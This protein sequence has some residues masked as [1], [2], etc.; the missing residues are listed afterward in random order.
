[1]RSLPVFSALLFSFAVS[2]EARAVTLYFADLPLTVQQSGDQVELNSFYS[3]GGVSAFATF[4]NSGGWGWLMRYDMT[5]PSGQTDFDGNQTAAYDGYLWM[6]VQNSYSAAATSHAITL[7]R[8]QVTP[9]PGNLFGQNDPGFTPDADADANGDL[10][11]FL[12]TADLLTGHAY[13][14]LYLDFESSGGVDSGNLQGELPVPCLATGCAIHAEINL[15]QLQYQL[16]GSTIQLAGPA[17]GFN[18]IDTRGLV[19]KQ[20]NGYFSPYDSPP[21]SNTVQTFAISAVPEPSVIAMLGCGL[22]M[23]AFAARRR[24]V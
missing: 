10:S 19:Y 1:M 23:V 24:R 7:Y 12:T 2:M 13:R 17:A 9:T 15:V 20:S 3:F 18:P 4:T 14:T 5:S 16:V 11:L 21:P 22:G 8:D 6:R